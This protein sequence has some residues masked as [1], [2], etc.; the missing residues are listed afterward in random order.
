[1]KRAQTAAIFVIIVFAATA[2]FGCSPSGP[3]GVAQAFVSAMKSRDTEAAAKHWNYITTA[4]QQN[5]NWDEIPEG[6]RNLIIGKLQEARAKEL[7]YWTQYF[8]PETTIVEVTE[9]G[10]KAEATL[11]G[12]RAGVLKLVKIDERWYVDGL[13]Q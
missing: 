6:Q 13:R 3:E 12:G 9:M 10:D 4:R 11:R 1:M 2:L 8:G 5:E 7:E